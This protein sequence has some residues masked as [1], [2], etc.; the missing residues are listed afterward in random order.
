[1]GNKGLGV[2]YKIENMNPESPDYGMVYIGQTSISDLTPLESFNKRIKQHGNSARLRYDITQGCSKKLYPAIRRD[3]WSNFDKSILETNI[4]KDD[5]DD[6][7]IHWIEVYDSFINGYNGNVGGGAVNV[8]TDEAR[9]KASNK[10]KERWA[11][12]EFRQAHSERARRY[13]DDPKFGEQ[14]RHKFRLNTL[15]SCGLTLE[16]Y[17]DSQKARRKRSEAMKSKIESNRKKR[18]EQKRLRDAGVIGM[19]SKEHKRVLSDRSR[20][21]FNDPQLGEQRRKQVAE[22]TREQMSKPGA[23]ELISETSKARWR[24]PVMRAK[25]MRNRIKPKERELPFPERSK[26]E[27]L[28]GSLKKRMLAKHNRWLANFSD[29]TELQ[30]I[31]DFDLWLFREFGVSL[32]VKKHDVRY[33]FVY[34]VGN[35]TLIYVSLAEYRIKVYLSSGDVAWLDDD[36]CKEVIAGYFN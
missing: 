10:A 29:I 9:N 15:K 16:D 34:M 8:W 24:D 22:K 26:A 17:E 21:Y 12:K 18:A 35:K 27:I 20:A 2:I 23:R 7:E 19:K 30:A 11:S 32:K 36:E 28:R 14:R 31:I 5:L 13:W 6:L 25:M 4:L 1:M 3:G 33:R